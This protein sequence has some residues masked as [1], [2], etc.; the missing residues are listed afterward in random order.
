MFRKAIS[1]LDMQN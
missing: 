1:W